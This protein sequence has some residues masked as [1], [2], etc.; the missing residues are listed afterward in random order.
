MRYV[1][2][3]ITAAIVAAS[4]AAIWW[5]WPLVVGT[6]PG[7][8]GFLPLFHAGRMLI[9]GAPLLTMLILF[10][11]LHRSKSFVW[12]MGFAALAVCGAAL[13]LAWSEYVRLA[14]SLAKGW[15]WRAL[16]EKHG[17]Q[18]G[19][20][21]AVFGPVFAMMLWGGSFAIPRPRRAEEVPPPKRSRS[22]VH[23]KAAFMAMQKVAK[24]L[25]GSGPIVL[26]ERYRVDKDEVASVPFDPRDRSTW[27]K[28]GTA[29]LVCYD[30]TTGA[31]STHGLIFAGS[32]GFKTTGFVI[33][34]LLRYPYS[35]VVIDPDRQTY[36]V[37]K[38]AR[39]AMNHRVFLVSPNIPNS[40]LNVLD[41]IDPT[42]P[43]A[44]QHIA[45]VTALVCNTRY[46]ANQAKGGH[47]YFESQGAALVTGL[48]AYL[49]FEPG[50]RPEQRTLRHLLEV[51]KQE[52]E[53]LIKQLAQIVDD[54]PH[55]FVKL[56]LAPFVGM[57][58]AT[59][60]GIF[61]NA[62]NLTDWL[63]FEPLADLVSGGKLKSSDIIDGR[64]DVFLAI[65]TA[66]MK[67]FPG[68]ARVILGAFVQAIKMAE[69]RMVGRALVVVDE[70][71]LLGRMELL[72][73]IRDT[74]RKYGISLV[75]AYQSVGQVRDQ[76]GPG[77][78]SAWMDSTT[79]QIFAALKDKDTAKW[80]SEYL[81]RYTAEVTSRSTSSVARGST[82][83]SGVN[84]TTTTNL[85]GVDLIRP[86]DITAGMR[87]DEQILVFAGSPIRCGRAIWFRRPEM[88][89]IAGED[90]FASIGQRR[91]AADEPPVGP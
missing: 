24:L 54:P 80:L 8:L 13:V 39:E 68:V 16:L 81:G 89:E 55:R 61:G 27:G 45:L 40:G 88:V 47:H 56:L 1:V 6:D 37:T 3:L 62:A 34:T 35:G 83:G 58:Y 11:V 30:P 22:S 74:T 75:M 60:S 25:P 82:G 26:G 33:P 70:A 78:L 65:N 49:V 48:L 52:P 76:W 32:G 69:R 14:P 72:E 91:A 41:W 51:V 28:G 50:L 36:A 4:S 77:G 87:S 63:T 17:D 64:T 79:W 5:G 7:A 9:V 38:K 67:Q 23:G 59:L 90:R 2:S 44:P 20:I 12:A 42:S 19:A 66:I 15:Q 85:V 10:G 86:E 73:E 18:A 57:V 29:P 31:G 21:G 53:D 43:E 84:R 46:H 71:A